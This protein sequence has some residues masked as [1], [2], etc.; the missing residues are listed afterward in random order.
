META[1]CPHLFLRRNVYVSFPVS[2]QPPPIYSLA[3]QFTLEN[4]TNITPILAVLY[5]PAV[6]RYNIKSYAKQ[7]TRQNSGYNSASWRSVTPRFQAG[8]GRGAIA[9]LPSSVR[10]GRG[11][12]L[13]CLGPFFDLLLPFWLPRYRA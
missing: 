13:H 6:T 2:P 12:F 11:L 8:Y 5:N 7:S 4:M 9:Y 1:I 10:T 3:L